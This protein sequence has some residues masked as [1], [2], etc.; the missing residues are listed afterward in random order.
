MNNKSGYLKVILGP[1]FAGKT[2]ELIRIYKTYHPLNYAPNKDIAVINYIGDTRYDNKNGVKYIV[3]HNND[4]LPSLNYEY[5]LN[6]I[7]ELNM[8]KYSVILI[9]EGQFFDDLYTAVDLLVNTY[10]KKVYVCGLDGDYKRNKFGD[11]LD[12]IS[13][14]DDVVKLKS[15]CTKCKNEAIFT[16]RKI[17]DNNQMLVGDN[18]YEPLCRY[19]YNLSNKLFDK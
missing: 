10:N 14:A 19:C 7:N 16:H 3:T 9:N 13:L 4:K 8:T 17:Q 6:F 11:I 18:I 12:I 15:I 1:M 2:S 5:L